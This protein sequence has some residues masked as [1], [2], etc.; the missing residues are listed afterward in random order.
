[1]GW[2]NCE[3][4][5]SA[6]FVIAALLVGCT[7][8]R[9]A[10]TDQ[11]DPETGAT[12]MRLD[13]PLEFVAT[14]R[15]ADDA[16]PFAYAAPFVTDR[17]GARAYF[18]WI[19]IPGDQTVAEAPELR[20]GEVPVSLRE[21]G[22]APPATLSSRPYDRPA[23]WS[24]DYYFEVDPDTLAGL[25]RCGRL[26]ITVHYTSAGAVRFESNSGPAVHAFAVLG[27]S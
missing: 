17:M 21:H 14:V 3:W 23:P 12:L 19:A 18:I 6:A 1:M 24:S 10:A 16:D 27:G 9:E 20:C 25:E 13:R 8:D 4:R 7:T 5:Y 22:A 2:C 26:A 15:R 11:L